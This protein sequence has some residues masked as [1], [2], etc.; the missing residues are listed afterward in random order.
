M[1]NAVSTYGAVTFGGRWYTGPGAAPGGT[2]VES[3]KNQVFG[4]T[5]R[6]CKGAATFSFVEFLSRRDIAAGRRAVPRI[7]GNLIHDNTVVTASGTPY[8]WNGSKFYTT[9]M[10]HSASKA[11]RWR[12]VNGNKL[13]DNH[14]F[15]PTHVYLIDGVFR[16]GVTVHKVESLAEFEASYAASVYRNG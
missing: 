9:V 3:L 8:S 15:N 1:R 11:P 16:G 13:Y 2:L 7:T 12:G 5:I 10:Y 14:G 6:N 4:N